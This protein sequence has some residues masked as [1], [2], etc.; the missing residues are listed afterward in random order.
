M[1]LKPTTAQPFYGY[2]FRA[3]ESQGASAKGGAKPYVV[4]G[5]STAGFA[6]IAYPVKFN[7]TGVQTFMINQDRVIY[8]KNLGNDTA[9]LAKA[10]TEFNP[11]N[12]WTAVQ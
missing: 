6:Y 7:D 4:S 10:T 5:K 3:L 9:T 11:D 2:Y 12:T 1:T 8:E